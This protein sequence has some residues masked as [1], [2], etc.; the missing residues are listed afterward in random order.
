MSVDT[1]IS[2]DSDTNSATKQER[3]EH[4]VIK[5]RTTSDKIPEHFSSDRSDSS[6]DTCLSDFSDSDNDNDDDD[7]TEHF[8]RKGVKPS[9]H[10]SV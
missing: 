2:V 10:K 7:G 1:D 9:I 8:V 4:H 6:S 3:S 5:C